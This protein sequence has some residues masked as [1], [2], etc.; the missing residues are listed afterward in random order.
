MG[1][2][3]KGAVENRGS[4]GHRIPRVEREIREVIGSYLLGGFRGDLPPFVSVSRV[5]A[6]R[7]L[8]NAKILVT[9][10]GENV[11][12][13][14]CVKE[15]QAHAHEIQRVVNQRLRM[16][17]CPRLTFHYDHGFEHALKVESILRDLSRE[18]AGKDAEASDEDSN[19]ES[20]ED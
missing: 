20:S 13:A 19:S 3:K 18:R 6:S 9:A 11:D 5:I 7:D 12:R 15:L 10:M 17:H 16:K 8:R 14:A 2:D 1:R 4:G